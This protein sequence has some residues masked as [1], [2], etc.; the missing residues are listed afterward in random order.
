MGEGGTTCANHWICGKPL[1]RSAPLADLSLRESVARLRAQEITPAELLI[2][3]AHALDPRTG[4][5]GPHDLLIRGGVIAEIGEAGTLSAAE[6][7][8]TLVMSARR[9]MIVGR[10]LRSVKRILSS[11]WRM[12]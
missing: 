4:I 10:K 5:D 12:M 7:F 8:S 1:A 3:G 11:A 2:R 9:S 6:T